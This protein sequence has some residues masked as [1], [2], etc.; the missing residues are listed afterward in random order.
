M[1]LL[2]GLNLGGEGGPDME[3]G[4]NMLMKMISGMLEDQ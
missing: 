4:D 2:A 3:G 1:D